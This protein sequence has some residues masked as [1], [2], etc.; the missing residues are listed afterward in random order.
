MPADPIM[1]ARARQLLVGME[2]E[3]FSPMEI[4]EKH[5]KGADKARQDIK[6]RLP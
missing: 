3:I 5:G 2:R 4:I 6:A 1:R